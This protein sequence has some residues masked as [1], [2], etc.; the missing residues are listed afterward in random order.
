MTLKNYF[1]LARVSARMKNNILNEL[2]QKQK[3]AV[4]C[5]NGA[6]LVL[7]GA[8]SGKTRVLTY[9]VA[10]LIHNGIEPSKILAVT[11]T[12]KAAK[13]MQN[14]IEH[15]IGADD[16]FSSKPTVGTFHSICVRILRREIETLKNGLTSNF[17]IFDTDDSLK[18]VKL[19]MKDLRID[20]K[21]V[22]P[23]AVL[24]HISAAKNQ[25]LDAE[26]FYEA[27]GTDSFNR[28]AKAVKQIFPIFKKRL[29]E[30]NALDFD[31]L[32][33]K[34][35]E[36]FENS[37]EVLEKYHNMWQYVLVDEYQ[38][39]NLAQY[40]LIRLLTDKHEN[41]CVVGDDHQSIYSFRGA[42]FRNI[43]DFEKDFPKAKIVKLEQNYRSTGNILR[44][45]NSLIDKNRTGRK[46]ELWTENDSGELL[47]VAGV[48]DEK[49]EGTFIANKLKE[50]IESSDVKYNNIA[51]LYRMNAQSRSIEEA[52]MRN[53]IP[54]QIVGGVRFF[55]RK[56]IKDVIAY[57]RVIFNPRDDVSFLRIINTPSRKLGPATLDVL[58]NYA[59]EYQIGL[60]QVLES[61]NELVELPETKRKVLSDFYK[62][63]MEFRKQMKDEPIS[64]ILD[65]LIKKIDFYKYLNDGSSEGESR[66]EN[67][68]ELFSVATKYD[69][70]EDS[71]A[72]FLEGVA[73]ISDLDRVE[74]TDT[75]TL[76]TV[77]AAKGLEF[78]IVFLPGWEENIF[79]SSS[80]QFDE[81]QL[82]E[83][84][85]L[86]YVAI[87][88]AEKKCFITH[89]QKRM[90]FGKTNFGGSS[91]FL[92]ELDQN[93][94]EVIPCSP[95]FGSGLSRGKN[96]SAQNYYNQKPSFK[97]TIPKSNNKKTEKFIDFQNQPKTKKEAI[98]G[99]AE[100]ETGYEISQSVHHPEY[101]DGTIIQISGDILSIAF[102][103]L[104]IKKVV[105]SVTPLTKI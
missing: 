91:Q 45:A 76:M 22:K 10:N 23:R 94:H 90:I 70:V 25:L 49:D 11:F 97:K 60:F 80:A 84:R 77:H 79:P 62:M 20:I 63:I 24:S 30:H 67:V 21:E 86:G 103:G 74:N 58:K 69:S 29:I 38:D 85:R 104:G 101:G 46:K 100:N 87:T 33:E 8:G 17:V 53:Q 41:L 71:L 40:K 89:A 66:I 98:F 9:R 95:R 92:A 57:L 48:L 26:E 4:E 35:V 15:I 14:R 37:S 16:I 2:N 3:E 51:V 75:V 61:V 72:T 50:Y 93:S 68:K 12:N 73:L 88:R 102:S 64:I 96:F 27:A 78:P 56:E 28:F 54:Y 1:K 81:S 82:E 39:T 31:D 105:S 19:I 99:V 55:D 47:T 83:E 13:E 36:V 7:A 32:L 44:N 5:L 65:H 59:T 34:T 18:L 43:L 6:L 42:D 52:F